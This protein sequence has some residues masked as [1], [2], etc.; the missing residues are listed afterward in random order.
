M[1]GALYRGG[2]TI[3]F[4]GAA[5]DPEDGALP[6][7]AFRWQV[8]FQHANHSVPF[9]GTLSGVTNGSFTV[10]TRGEQATNVFFRILLTVTDS[11][12]RE[13]TVFRDILPRTSTLTFA[14]EPAGLQILLDGVSR[15]T[16]AVVPCV[17]GMS[18]VLSTLSPVSGRDW[19]A[20]SDG[21]ALTHVVTVP[22][23]NA[24][25]TARFRTP[26]TLVPTNA[27]WRYLVTASAPSS[28][29]K[30]SNFDDSSWLLGAAQLG[31]GDGDE[32][33]PIGYG[34]DPNNKYV[35]TYFRR[36]FTVAD[37]SLFAALLVRLLRDD[38]GIVYLNGTEIFRS[39]MGGGASLYR[40]EAPVTAQAADE[41]TRFYTTNIAPTL[42]R[43]GTNVIAAEIHQNGANSA[44][45]SFALELR[46]AE[47]DPLVSVVASAPA[48]E[49]GTVAGAFTITRS[50]PLSNTLGVNF[51]L[52]GTALAGSDFQGIGSSISFAVD[53]ASKAIVIM[54][55]A[56]STVEG[57]ETVQL[58]L[59]TG[60]G[61]ALGASAMATVMIADK[62]FDDWRFTHG[63]ANSSATGDPDGDGSVNLLEF[64]IGSDPN[65][66]A[67]APYP[68]ISSAGGQLTLTYQRLRNAAE[69]EYRVEVSRDLL[70]WDYGAAFV[71]EEMQL[72]GLTVIAR[73]LASDGSSN[74]FIRL[75]VI[76]LP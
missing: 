42:L 47:R 7:S 24:A 31:F 40:T 59:Q 4:S 62:P 36:S 51:Q 71:Q 75:R 48:A 3:S 66:S 39:N 30:T 6:P 54:P 76:E 1:S 65:I 13:T 12:G 5:D 23:T 19:Q 63:L 69:M 25:Y 55:I 20:W 56:D 10:P 27:Q 34:P 53:E 72:D 32:T 16:P 9:L 70:T 50:T 41:T 33:T 28:L 14:S 52:G 21:G 45:L 64:A 11:G 49:R 43:S 74:R 60:A 37:P 35:T 58:N 61:Y 17:V 2:E 57:S 46:G 15:A 44:D 29:W 26:I 8:L 67:P 68:I 22:E 73:D 38:G 18:R